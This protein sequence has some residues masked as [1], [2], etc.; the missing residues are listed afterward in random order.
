MSETNL[1]RF[2]LESLQRKLGVTSSVNIESMD[3]EELI[4]TYAYMLDKAR[5][6]E[7]RARDR[8]I[9]HR[10]S[11][12][13]NDEQEEENTLFWILTTIWFLVCVF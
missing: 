7:K 9:Q 2:R 5:Q 11:L 10:L 12:N 13:E 3:D 6:N 8:W 1:Y 4:E